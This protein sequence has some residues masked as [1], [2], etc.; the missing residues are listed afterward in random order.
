MAP[1]SVLGHHV[2][3]NLP[4]LA[5]PG[6]VYSNVGICTLGDIATCIDPYSKG[7]VSWSVNGQALVEWASMYRLVTACKYSSFLMVYELLPY[8]ARHNCEPWSQEKTLYNVIDYVAIHKH[9]KLLVIKTRSYSSTDIFSDK[10]H[11]R[12]ESD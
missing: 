12:Y 8:M 4:C 11:G 2:P 6:V 7:Y 10:C 1:K 5:G 9:C 3:K